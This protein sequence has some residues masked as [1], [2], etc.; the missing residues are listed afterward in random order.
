MNEFLAFA[1]F[2]SRHGYSTPILDKAYDDLVDPVLLVDVACFNSRGSFAS[3]YP[4]DP[5]TNAN[6][7]RVFTPRLR[8]LVEYLSLP[9]GRN[10]RC[11]GWHCWE[12]DLS[13]DLLWFP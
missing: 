1:S 6:G 7:S 13:G 2:V 9:F 5:V 10:C 11:V 12:C 3:S 4:H 8:V